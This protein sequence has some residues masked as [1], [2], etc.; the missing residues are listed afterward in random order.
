MPIMRAAYD[1]LHALTF[2][3]WALL[4]V[5]HARGVGAGRILAEGIRADR[6][7]VILGNDGPADHH[8]G[9]LAGVLQML[10]DLEHLRLG[11]GQ[12]RAEAD[13]GIAPVAGRGEIGQIAVAHGFEHLDGND[14]VEF[15][16]DVAV[17]GQLKFDLI[18]KPRSGHA[19]FGVIQLLLRNG[20]GGNATAV[21]FGGVFG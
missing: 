19:L 12:K 18:G 11:R 5:S 1:A 7:G 20:D 2:A 14:L 16:G 13:H 17:I 15:A 9:G 21:I 8:L 6:V 3:S 4:L 10:D